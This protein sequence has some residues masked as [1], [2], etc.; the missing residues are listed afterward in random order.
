[1]IAVD[2]AVVVAVAV[3][4]VVAVAAV[5][6]AAEER[7]IEDVDKKSFNVGIRRGNSGRICAILA[8]FI[9][10]KVGGFINVKKFV[11][12][13]N[14]L[15]YRGFYGSTLTLSNRRLAKEQRL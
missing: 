4:V 14:D 5:S 1:M 10:F 12:C 11:Y 6:V 13:T 7:L 15:S 3:D 9:I 8:Q 2:D